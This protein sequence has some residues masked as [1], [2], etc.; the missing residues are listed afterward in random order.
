MCFGRRVAKG[1]VSL[2]LGVCVRVHISPCMCRGLLVWLCASVFVLCCLHCKN[3]RKVAKLRTVRSMYDFEHLDQ[4]D[5]GETLRDKNTE[6]DDKAEVVTW[7]SEEAEESIDV[8]MKQ[9]QRE[10]TASTC[11]IDIDVPKDMNSCWSFFHCVAVSFFSFVQFLCL[12]VFMSTVLVVFH[13]SSHVTCV[14]FCGQ[15]R[16]GTYRARIQGCSFKRISFSIW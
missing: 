3:L 4:I 1:C 9:V 2:C 15:L 16:S 14:A 10:S 11:K 6:E 7:M 12:Y 8:D 13:T 5:E